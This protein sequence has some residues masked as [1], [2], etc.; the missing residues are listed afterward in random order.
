MTGQWADPGTAEAAF[1][2]QL[3]ELGAELLEPSGRVPT[4]HWVRYAT[5]HEVTCSPVNVKAGRDVCFKCA[6][7]NHSENARSKAATEAAFRTILKAEG[8]ELLE[9]YRGRHAP[10]R[11][12]GPAGH[13]TKP[14][15]GSILGGTGVCQTC[16][17]YG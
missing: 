8:A 17:R 13:V 3:A 1:R 12:R 9:P 5:G 2:T 16:G 11:V 15:S 10:H 4:I 7:A 14:H 6:M